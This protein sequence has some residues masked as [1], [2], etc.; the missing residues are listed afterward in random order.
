MA[1]SNQV[2][3]QTHLFYK[4][5]L[6]RNGEAEVEKGWWTQKGKERVR[7]TDKVTLTDIHYH[8]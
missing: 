6:G 4:S 8:V 5:M 3:I 1:N 7:L 2:I